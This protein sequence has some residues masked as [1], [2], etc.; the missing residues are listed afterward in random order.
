MMK[1]SKLLSIYVSVYCYNGTCFHWS[2]LCDYAYT[3]VYER[4]MTVVT[5]V[6]HPF[7]Y[8]NP[9]PCEFPVTKMIELISLPIDSGIS[10]V[11]YLA[12]AMRFRRDDVVSQF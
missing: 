10:H 7:L 1:M 12:I 2:K 9:L 6:F 11:I 4:L 5:P 3:C 8:S